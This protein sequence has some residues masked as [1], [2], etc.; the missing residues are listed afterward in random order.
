M[1]KSIFEILDSLETETSV[2]A[3]GKN[4]SQTIPRSQFPTAEQ[5]EDAEKLE[6]W[7]RETG[8][9]HAALQSG[10]Q[11]RLI[12]IR[13]IFKSEKK[14]E[15]WTP[16]A[17]QKKVNES[18]WSIVERPKA[19]SSKSVDSARYND[20]MKMVANM[21]MAKMPT[22]QIKAIAIPVYGEELVNTIFTTLE[23]LNK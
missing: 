2:P 20:C 7:A 14:G 18:E 22:D 5:F 9:M 3:V 17:G 6:A 8:H 23:G 11:K 1:A 12:D 21:C 10:V 4:V 16:E 13:A 19:G 15:T